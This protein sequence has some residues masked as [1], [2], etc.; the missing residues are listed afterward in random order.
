M[1]IARNEV[2]LLVHIPRYEI[3]LHVRIRRNEIQVIGH[4][5]SSQ[6]TRKLGTCALHMVLDA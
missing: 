6:G 5:R 1:R 2:I 4:V 3:I